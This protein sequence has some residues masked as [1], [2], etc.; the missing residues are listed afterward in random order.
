MKQFYW[1]GA[2]AANQAEG[3]YLEDGKG[4]STADIIQGGSK[5]K[6]R[7]WSFELD[8]Q[9]YYPT[10]TAVDFYHHYQEDIAMFAEMGFTMLRLS[11]NWSRIFPNGDDEVANEQGLIFYE[12]VFQECLK[13]GIEPMVTISHYETPLHLMKQYNGWTDR[14]VVAF[15]VKYAETVMQRYKELVRYWLPFNE[16]NGMVIAGGITAGAYTCDGNPSKY[17]TRCYENDQMRFQALHHQFLASAITVLKGKQINPKFVFGT[18]IAH[19]TTYPL[20]PNPKDV[21][22]AQKRDQIN[23][24]IALD[25][26]IRGKYTKQYWNY[27]NQLGIRLV[28]QDED[29]DIIGKGTC[30]IITFAYYMS[31]CATTDTNIEKTSGNLIGGAKNPYLAASSWGWQIDP[32]GLRYTINKLYNMYH[33]PIMVVEN[34]LGAEDTVDENG[35]IHDDYRIEYLSQHI[36]AMQQAIKDGSDCIGY[37]S[38]GPLDIISA[39]TGEMAKRYGY[40]YVNKHD[41]GSGDYT[42]VRKK[43]FYWYR[44][45]I[46]TDA[47]C[48]NEH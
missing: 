38:W 8:E 26:M 13:Y 7:I 39:S 33:V 25:V 41:D 19:I 15:F 21:L 14:R 31:N 9:A 20:T 47:K 32:D 30:D 1:G 46:Q 34:G 10:H 4:L 24:N 44:Q 35:E 18:M 22:L 45:V 43:S 17:P 27:L 2:L 40:I 16:I 28:I 5:N 3:A 48:I 23:N 11:I 36:H 42:R 37:L 12:K 6:E 29:M